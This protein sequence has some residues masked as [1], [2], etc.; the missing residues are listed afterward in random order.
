LKS[1]SAAFG[2]KGRLGYPRR[3]AGSAC[4]PFLCPLPPGGK[5]T[6]P[7]GHTTAVHPG[8]GCR[9]LGSPYVKYTAAPRLRPATPNARN[10]P[11]SPCRREAYA[12]TPG[13]WAATSTDLAGPAR[14]Q[15]P[16][17]VERLWTSPS[18][19]RTG[20]V[21]RPTRHPPRSSEDTGLAQ[22]PDISLQMTDSDWTCKHDPA[23][24]PCSTA[25][26]SRQRLLCKC[27]LATTRPT[28]G[29]SKHPSVSRPTRAGPMPR[30]D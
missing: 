4:F 16:S 3:E 11:G 26:R 30:R 23:G 6:S 9:Q 22:P 17:G 5:G 1:T 12:R 25:A 14:P 20:L 28:A 7:R 18:W 24:A 19:T 21:G 29:P 8:L 2:N 10:R 27:G 15:Q 13:A